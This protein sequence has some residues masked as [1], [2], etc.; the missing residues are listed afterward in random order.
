[1]NVCLYD[2]ALP[3]CLV[4]TEVQKGCQIPLLELWIVSRMSAE[5][6]PRSSARLHPQHYRKLDMSASMCLDLCSF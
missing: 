2:S 6:C 4:P 1:M 5:N 3:A